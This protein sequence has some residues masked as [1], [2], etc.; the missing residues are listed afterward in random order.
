MHEVIVERFM[1]VFSSVHNRLTVLAQ[2]SKSFF[3]I[4]MQHL[5]LQ[6]PDQSKSLV[7]KRGNNTSPRRLPLMNSA[8]K[9]LFLRTQSLPGCWVCELTQSI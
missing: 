4:Q 7:L 9:F 3:L 1:F 8:Q 2:F 6:K 5:G